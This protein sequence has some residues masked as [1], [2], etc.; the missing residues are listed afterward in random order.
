[1]P[2]GEETLAPLG[3]NGYAT[4]LMRVILRAYFPL[5]DF[6]RY[7]SIKF[8]T[9]EKTTDESSITSTITI[10]RRLHFTLLNNTIVHTY[11]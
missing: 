7:L 9:S 11:I 8:R 4:E 1:M 10:R 6:P 2:K 3:P 5:P